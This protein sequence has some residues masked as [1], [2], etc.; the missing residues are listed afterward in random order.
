MI[1]E[2]TIAAAAAYVR[3]LLA[4]GRPA[5]GRALW[6]ESGE[7]RDTTVAHFEDKLLLLADGMSTQA[8]RILAARRGAY[9]RGFYEEFVAEWR[10]ER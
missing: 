1:D 8:G 2:G 3:D 5:M 7:C 6:D 10:G 9:L 4:G